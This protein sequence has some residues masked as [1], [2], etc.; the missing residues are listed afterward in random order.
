MDT[1]L[2]RT[3]ARRKYDARGVNFVA[4]STAVPRVDFA[5]GD[6]DATLCVPRRYATRKS[7]CRAINRLRVLP[8]YFAAARRKANS[9]SSTDLRVCG[10]VD[11]A[12]QPVLRPSGIIRLELIQPLPRL[13]YE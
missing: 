6:A 11:A 10:K 1:R 9:I 7:S 5:S 13:R 8:V 2:I 3:I 4:R 12:V